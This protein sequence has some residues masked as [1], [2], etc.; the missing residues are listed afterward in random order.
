MVRRR[1]TLDCLSIDRNVLNNG[2]NIGPVGDFLGAKRV[3]RGGGG[4]LCIATLPTFCVA[5][6]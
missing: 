3:R 4:E 1:D 6:I 2:L 5:R